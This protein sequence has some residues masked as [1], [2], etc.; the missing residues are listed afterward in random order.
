VASNPSREARATDAAGRGCLTGIGDALV[1]V[2][3]PAGCL[4]NELLT[5]TSRVPIS[6]R[7]WRRS[8]VWFVNWLADA[9]V[10]VPLLRRRE[11]ERG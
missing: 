3:F 1:S 6:D 8:G 7:A 11:R 4:C 2:F 10:P 5:G 9:L